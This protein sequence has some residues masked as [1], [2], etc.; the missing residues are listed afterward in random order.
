MPGELVTTA[1]IGIRR[2]DDS[3][4]L[5]TRI[6]LPVFRPEARSAHLHSDFCAPENEEIVP[7]KSARPRISGG[8]VRQVPIA[9]RFIYYT[10]YD[11]PRVMVLLSA[12]VPCFAST[13]SD[14]QGLAAL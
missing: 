1:I 7:P 10:Q 13:R 6:C 12:G 14:E 5:M 11:Y 9:R 2:E 4:V 8:L 3:E